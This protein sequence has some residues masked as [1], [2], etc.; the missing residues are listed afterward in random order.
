MKHIY[1]NYLSKVLTALSLLLFVTCTE[2]NDLPSSSPGRLSLNVGL[3]VA[4]PGVYNSL[5]AAD[6]DEF[7]IEIYND[8]D[9]LMIGYN[10]I[11]EVPETIELPEGIYY[12]TAH[13][14]NN[15]PA[16]F[17]NPYY[18]G[19]TENFTISAGQETTATIT[20]SLANIMITVVYS[21]NVAGVFTGYSTS[22][23]NS[24]GSLVFGMDET[25]AGFFSEG[26]L[27]IESTLTYDDGS[28]TTQTKNLS[29]D[30]PVPEAGKHYEIHIDAAL[31]GGN[32]IIS[33]AVDETYETEVVT[34]SDELTMT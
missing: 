17:E 14:D 2:N 33:L 1:F 19:R 11:S 18:F 4:A 12:A 23:S 5:K 20:C 10:G 27:H 26:P 32:A 9:E 13:S 3:S 8:L 7:I 24:G 15:L 21:E 29:G 30:I 22:V 28:G 6:L 31:P 25:R 16:E 34:I